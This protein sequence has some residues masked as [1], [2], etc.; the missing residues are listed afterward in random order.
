ML[1][2]I[3]A[4]VAGCF[5][6]TSVE[7]AGAADLDVNATISKSIDGFIRPGYLRFHDATTAL[8]KAVDE[9]CAAPS[10]PALEAARSVFS[11]TVDSWSAVEIIRF[12]P[13]TEQDR[14]ERILYWPDRKSIGLKQVQ[15]GLAEKDPTVTDAAQ[16]AGKSVAMQGLG[17]L[18]FVLYGTGAED[19]SG[20]DGQFRC[21]YGLAIAKNLDSMAGELANEWEDPAGFLQQWEGFGAQSP[22]YRDGDEA[23]TEL[24]EVFVNGLE[25]IRDQRLGGFFG[26]EAKGDKPK[27]ALFWR[28][29]KTADALTAN[30]R[31]LEALFDASGIGAALPE[32]AHWIGQSADFEF[33]NAINAA[34][35]A[36][37]TVDQMLDDPAKR[38]KLAYFGVVTSSLSEI[39]ATR[40]SAELGLTAGFSS[41][42]GD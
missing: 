26:D 29:G 35:A 10:K 20:T 33:D 31:G 40:L 28:S 37:G 30:M 19:L 24:L 17:S 11:A 14:L 32:S 13:V 21:S 27:Q 16:L 25:L 38:G 15:A 5:F 23:L 34:E 8:A 12:G 22:L 41:L 18:E 36:K 39:F 42:D 6:L 3:I 2:K 4:A 9:L 7:P 1:R